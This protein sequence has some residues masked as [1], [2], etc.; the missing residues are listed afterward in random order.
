MRF[1]TS[2]CTNLVQGFVQ[3]DKGGGYSLGEWRKVLNLKPSQQESPKT[4]GDRFRITENS[5]ALLPIPITLDASKKIR[6]SVDT[7]YESYTLI[8]CNARSSLFP[9]EAGAEDK[10]N[11]PRSKS[12]EVSNSGTRIA[13]GIAC[14]SALDVENPVVRAE[15]GFLC[16]YCSIIFLL[17]SRIRGNDNK[18]LYDY[19]LKAK[20]SKNSFNQSWK[21]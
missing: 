21:R 11:Y 1:F 4:K 8:F 18:E 9:K 20:A 10:T 17:D 6:P 15:S 13:Q 2:P 5:L 16:G 3:N 12:F 7:K 19:T 14:H